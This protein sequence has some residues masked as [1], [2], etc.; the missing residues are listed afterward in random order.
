M[1][2]SKVLHLIEQK[3]TTQENNDYMVVL[4]GAQYSPNPNVFC[5]IS[6][7]SLKFYYSSITN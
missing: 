4:S 6:N 3:R 5:I 7:H 1:Y 2:A